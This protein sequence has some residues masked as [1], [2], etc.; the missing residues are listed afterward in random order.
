MAARP[1]G[2]PEQ[3]TR[4]GVATM[5]PLP[6]SLWAA[7]AMSATSY[8]KLE[9]DVAADCVIVGGGFTGLS[10]ALHLAARGVRAVLLEANEPGWG[11]SGRNG[12]QVIPGLKLDPSE[13][14]AKYGEERGRRLTATVGATADLVFDLIRQHRIACSARRSGW[15]QGAPGPKGFIEV[16]KRAEAWAAL[17]ADVALLDRDEVRARIGGGDYVGAFL[18]RRGGTLNP[19]SYARG[20]ARASAAAGAAIHGDSPAVAL[21]RAGQRWKVST[22]T[23]SVTAPHAVLCTNAYTDRLWPGL[24]Q[25]VV[26]VLSSVVATEPLSDNL[27]KV[28][29]PGREGVSETRRVLNWFGIDRDGR[30]IFGGRASQRETEDPQAF[31]PVLARLRNLLPILGEPRIQFRWAGHVA[32]TTDHVPHLNALAPNL[33]AG[34]G[35]NGRGV[36]M[37]TMMGKLLAERVAGAHDDD[38]PL[39]ATPVA[40]IPF[41]GWRATGIALAIGWK[42]LQ[43]RLHP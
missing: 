21:E 1:S 24:A 18:D 17:G 5:K 11:A 32:L 19:L 2:Q 7:T 10:T 25:T 43:D 22:P 31:R 40:R 26:P 23:G 15:I 41:Y 36:A 30:L 3:E 34:L 4:G 28:I 16:S 27:R 13:L 33:H 6:K 42:R 20:L 29:L 9:S 39:P 38:M 37:S 35:Y 14:S 8:P 12:G